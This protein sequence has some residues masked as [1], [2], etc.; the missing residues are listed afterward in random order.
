[1][2]VVWEEDQ[3]YP[4]VLPHLKESREIVIQ[5]E[6]WSKE[7]QSEKP[8]NSEGVIKSI[9][10]NWAK[11]SK[12]GVPGW[13]SCLGFSLSFFF[14][15]SPHHECMWEPTHTLYLSFSLK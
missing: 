9:M 2:E 1:M 4:I 13:L 3:E 11:M 12:A 14:C 15:P 7:E 5:Y 8:E 6:K 10:T